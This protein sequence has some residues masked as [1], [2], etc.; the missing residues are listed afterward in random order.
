MRDF[1]I[2][3]ID[4]EIAIAKSGKRGFVL[5]KM[6]S[7][8]DPEMMHKIYEA[9]RAGVK[10][11]LIV[12]G[13]F[14]L[15]TEKDGVSENI[16]AISI[17]DK[18]LEHSRIFMFGNGGDEKFYISS[19]DWMPRNLD[20]R[21]EVACPIY[22]KEIQEELRTMLKIQLR[23]NTKSRILDN[24]LSNKYSR[25]HLEGRFRAQEDYYQYIKEKHQLTMKI[26]HNPRC[27]KS[28]AGL[29]YLQENGHPVIVQNYIKEGITP[30]EIR[31]I[32]SKTGLSAIEL[33]RKHEELYLKKYKDKTISDEEW[34]TILAE[35]PQLLQRPIVINGKKAILA[36]PPELIQKI[37]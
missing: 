30:E 18:Y 2:R 28:R 14:G 17:V 1:F 24:E 31:S 25:Q 23:D 11:R 29:N 7:L 5:L 10:I 9:A 16:E 21:I 26:Y 13:I 15:L 32:I 12:R 36:Q 19:A 37:L 34:P 33:V 22:N 3:M 4:N 6:N 20:R 35:N 8:I 27:S